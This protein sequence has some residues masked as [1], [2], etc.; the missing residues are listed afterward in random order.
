MNRTDPLD[1]LES[2]AGVS[3]EIPP[4]PEDYEFE[5][6]LVSERS[7]SDLREFGLNMVDDYHD[8]KHEL[9]SWLANYGK[10]PE[11]REGLARSTL[12]STHYKLETAFRW[13]WRY[14]GQYTTKL[15]PDHA[16]KFIRVL[17]QSDGMIDSTV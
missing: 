17:D 2:G 16:D 7:K 5:Y 9:L 12:E 14:E 1:N 8:F 15:T 3:A 10:N 11:K 6:P 4:A 13:L